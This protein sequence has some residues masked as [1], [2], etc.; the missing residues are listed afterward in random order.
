MGSTE[1]DGLSD[2][3]YQAPARTA[4]PGHAVDAIIETIQPDPGIVLV[5]QGH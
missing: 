1:R 2:R 3:R 5:T 4:E